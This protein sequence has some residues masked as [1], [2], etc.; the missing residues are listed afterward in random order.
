MKQLAGGPMAIPQNVK[1]NIEKAIR[2]TRK[3]HLNTTVVLEA[4]CY[5]DALGKQLFG[6]DSGP[7]FKKY[8]E[9][10][11][12]D[13]FAGLK[14]RSNLLGQR[15]HFCLDALYGDIRCGVVHEIDPKFP[16]AIAPRGRMPVHLNINDKRW[17]GKK[18]VLCSPGF[19]DDF[20]N[21]LR[22]L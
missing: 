12:P 20:L 11:M 8:I 7:R 3:A 14:K 15:D 18:L 1:T 2:R 9:Q 10:H 5:I 6:G 13:T 21:S 19:V 22:N 4:C 17:P 16:S